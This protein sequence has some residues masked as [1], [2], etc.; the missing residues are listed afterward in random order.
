MRVAVIGA[1][2]TGLSAALELR[3]QGVDVMVL[4]AGDRAG[5][6]IT[7][8]RIDGFL[9]ESGPTSLTADRKSVV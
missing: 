6:V 5:G 7:T 3:D 9:V 4:D 2:V 1:G 8:R